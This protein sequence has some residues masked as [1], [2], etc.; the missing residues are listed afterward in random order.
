MPKPLT[1]YHPTSLLCMCYFAR[2]I[3]CL[4]F[5]S[6]PRWY[7]VGIL[8]RYSIKSLINLTFFSF[9]FAIS[10]FRAHLAARCESRMR[11]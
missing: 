2:A 9:I 11:R 6:G 7:E 10:V 3:L 1:F 4:L 8:F 5:R